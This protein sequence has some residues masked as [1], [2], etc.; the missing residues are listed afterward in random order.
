MEE[1]QT[2]QTA[3]T[4]KKEWK[5]VEAW[6]QE[7]EQAFQK[8][9]EDV[10]TLLGRYTTA[11][12]RENFY[13]RNKSAIAQ[14]AHGKTSIS[15]VMTGFHKMTKADETYD[16]RVELRY[17]KTSDNRVVYSPHFHFKR[18]ELIINSTL[19]LSTNA[20]EE[21][22]LN[23]YRQ[24]KLDITATIGGE[25]VRVSLNEVELTE[26]S[27]TRQLSRVLKSSE[28][29]R[30][31]YW[32]SAEL[33]KNKRNIDKLVITQKEKVQLPE[34]DIQAL[35]QTDHLDRVI[36]VGEGANERHYVIAVDRGL[37]K[38]ALVPTPAFSFLNKVKEVNLTPGDIRTLLSGKPVTSTLAYG[39][40]AGAEVI[41][42]LDPIQKK[43][44][45]ELSAPLQGQKAVQKATM[46]PSLKQAQ[47]QVQTQKQ[48]Q[49]PAAKQKMGR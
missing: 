4:A 40:N 43:L 10:K 36:K 33:D 37:N 27:A 16:A 24:S 5:S 48:A 19:T 22:L 39:N 6:K 31:E 26:L 28:N 44:A 11:A 42:W 47:A 38:L 8:K 46:S 9:L 45:L 30:Y 2:Q 25:N 17:Y 34:A 12:D 49:A 23:G 20:Q 1:Q 7:R 32:V 14:L 3:T 13:A 15:E 29:S 18:K 41:A 35:K 21:Y